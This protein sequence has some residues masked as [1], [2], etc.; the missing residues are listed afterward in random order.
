MKSGISD[1][2]S[3]V[4][5]TKAANVSLMIGCMSESSIGINQSVHFAAGTGAFK[6]C[7]LDSFILIKEDKFRGK[8]KHSDTRAVSFFA[9]EQ[10]YAQI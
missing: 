8:F 5:M 1:A 4:E 9:K 2:L 10:K 7:D 3:I 6:Y